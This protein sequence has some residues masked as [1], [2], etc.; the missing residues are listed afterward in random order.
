MCAFSEPDVRVSGVRLFALA[1]R[2]FG[3]VGNDLIVAVRAANR[4]QSF[5]AAVQEVD[6]PN[7]VHEVELLRDDEH[8]LNPCAYGGV[9]VADGETPV[10]MGESYYQREEDRRKRYLVARHFLSPRDTADGSAVLA[11]GRAEV[12]TASAL[13]S[14]TPDMVRLVRLDS[15]LLGPDDENCEEVMLV[16]EK[17]YGGCYE[18]REEGR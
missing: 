18:F 1:V 2:L 5:T 3:N 14:G 9:M 11:P 15:V 13:E 10:L 6:D 17:K 7:N 8:D 12:F 16:P 4:A